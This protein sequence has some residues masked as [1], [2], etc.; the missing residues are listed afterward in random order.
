MIKPKKHSDAPP[1]AGLYVH[2]PFCVK[3]CR[4]C[5]FYSVADL[6]LIPDVVNALTDEIDL[7]A[8]S[9][10]VMEGLRFDTLYFGGGTPSVLHPRDIDRI[11]SAARRRFAF[12]SD[13]EITLEM[14]PGTADAEKIAAFR[15]V[16]VNR[17]N[18]GVQSFRDETLRFL[19]R[20]HTAAEGRRALDHA[21]QAGFDRI[22]LDL[23]YALPG[24]T[25]TAWRAELAEA[26]QR[27]PEH[28]SC[29][30]LTWASGTPLHEGVLAGRLTP[31]PEEETRT[32][33]L[34]TISY[35]KANRYLQYEISNFARSRALRSRHNMKY[36]DD[37]PCL[38][39]GPSAHS[40]LNGTRWRNRA[41]VN[42]YL[43]AI[44]NGTS[45]VAEKETLT[46]EQKIIEALYLGLRKTAGIDLP[47]FNRAFGMDFVSAF[48]PL[49]RDLTADG[50]IASDGLSCRLTRKGM[51]LADG[52]AAL[53]A[54]QDFPD[55]SPFSPKP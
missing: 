35:L 21:E 17:I 16:G 33:F 36:W 37:V 20:I 19:G 25:P 3:K 40:Y 8:A 32:L 42:G 51:A 46:R 52:V 9:G 30:M 50:V 2:I 14:N 47:R 53:F 6:S 49:L 13:A 44:R 1:P 12:S 4:H 39:F 43:S 27:G 48:A 7:P 29:Y 18:I 22:G 26:V 45:P 54:G 34:E 55:F 41:S 11:I 10:D 5:D 31:L 28:L 15:R 24:Q 38:G 23:I